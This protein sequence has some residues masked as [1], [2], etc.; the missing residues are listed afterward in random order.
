MIKSLERNTRAIDTDRIIGQYKGKE[1][2]PLVLSIGGMHGNESSGVKALQ[3]V[4]STLQKNKPDFKGEIIGLAGNL[5]ALSNGVRFIDRDLNRMWLHEGYDGDLQDL[6]YSAELEEYNEISRIYQNSLKERQG[7]AIFIDLHT[8]SSKSAPFVLIGDTLRNRGFV[9]NFP[10]P[11]ILGLEEELD[12]PLLSH[13]NQLGHISFGFE[14]GQ[15]DDPRSVDNHIALLWLSL[16][17]AGCID[18]K[19]VP[20]YQGHFDLLS[21]QTTGLQR[22]FEVRYRYGIHENEGFSMDPGYTNFQEIGKEEK[23]AKNNHR[24]IKS[25]EK[26]LIFMPLYQAQGDDG[27]FVIRPIQK[28]WLKLSVFLRKIGLP[29]LLV[30]LPGIRRHPSHKHVLILNKKIARFFGVEIFH[31]LGYRK[32]KMQGKKLVMIRRKWDLREPN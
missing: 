15:H 22:F 13:I 28:F 25:P 27:F 3:Q 29:R 26:G 7:P 11:V 10:L 14:A 2:G 32:K 18:K 6:P 31:L 19:D 20:D 1:A 5:K 23:I 21:K 9:Q 16:V 24:Q 8:T 12:G 4:L 17:Q 30:A